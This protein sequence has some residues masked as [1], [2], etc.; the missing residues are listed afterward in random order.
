VVIASWAK[1]V[2]ENLLNVA[3]TR[4]K[5]NIY[6]IGNRYAWASAGVFG[7]LESRLPPIERSV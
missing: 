2:S 3:V 1:V 5:E 4:A 6:V 7:Q